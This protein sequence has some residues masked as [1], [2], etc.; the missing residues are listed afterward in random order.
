MMRQKALVFQDR[1]V[2]HQILNTSDV[3]RIKAL[4]RAV[5]NYNDIIWAGLR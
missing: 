2:A 3:A 4:G 5:R 1:E